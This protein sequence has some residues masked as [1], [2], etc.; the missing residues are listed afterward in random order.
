MLDGQRLSLRARMAGFLDDLGMIEAALWAR[1][2]LGLPLLTVL[3]YH[4]VSDTRLTSEFDPDVVDAGISEFDAQIATLASSFD[5]V[6]MAEIERHFADGAPLPKNPA[7]ITF[8]DGYRDCFDHALPTLERHGAKAV[9]FVSTHYLT[10][11][12]I[13]WWDRLSYLVKHST[14]RKLQLSYPYRIE[15]DMG[16][17]RATTLRRL[18]RMVKDHYALDL[19]RFLHDVEDACGVHID[20]TT[21]RVFANDLLMT[22]DQ[23]RELRKRGMDV[24]SH[25]RTHRILQTLSTAQLSDELRGSRCE[26]EEILGEPVRAIAYPVGRSIADDERVCRAV[27]EAGYAIGFSNGTGINVLGSEANPLDV[28][29]LAVESDVSP[30]YFRA[31]IAFPLFAHKK[32]SHPR[33]GVIRS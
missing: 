3:T 23:V 17:G 9:F 15:L 25:T 21:E 24:Q 20:V 12:R 28:S 31:A 6:G 4:R 30:S 16:M 5:I 27:R 7:L 10:E 19:P 11:R 14:Q 32:P 2:R 26:L 29:R 1:R 22:W 18:L 8:D 13:F 33:R